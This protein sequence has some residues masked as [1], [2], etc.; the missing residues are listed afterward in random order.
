M[1]P[2]NMQLMKIIKMCAHMYYRCKKK[3]DVISFQLL[4]KMV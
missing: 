2:E 1:L 3:F 4:F